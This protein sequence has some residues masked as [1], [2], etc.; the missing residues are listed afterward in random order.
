MNIGAKPILAEPDQRYWRRR[1]NRKVRK[2]RWTSRLRRWSAVAAALVIIGMAMFQAGSHAV[3]NFKKRAGLGVERIELRG[4]EHGGADS[5]LDLLANYV[6]RNIVDVNLYEIAAVAESHPWV[7]RAS[8]KRVLPGTLQV[9]I[10]ERHPAAI[11][12]IDDVAYVVDTTGFVV[13]RRQP[14]VY[15]HLPV[16]VGFDG[17]EAKDLAAALVRGTRAIA[18]LH[19][20][21]GVW[22][23]QIAEMNFSSPDRIAVRTVD[24]GPA[25]LL[26]PSRVERNLNRY[27]ELRREIARRAG[28]LEYVDLRWRER[29]SVMPAA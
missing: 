8:A 4:V 11:A 29:I 13:G 9:T 27:L 12:V 1:A 19:R 16:F 21:A 5:I 7:L 2:A 20:A 22:V 26:D 15:E 14:G 18:R 17:L 10:T 23:G 25:I 24:A 6:G 28:R 3:D